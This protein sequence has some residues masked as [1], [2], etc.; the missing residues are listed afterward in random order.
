MRLASD[1]LHK[2]WVGVGDVMLDQSATVQCVDDG[3]S[4]AVF[5]LFS[6]RR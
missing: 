6:K 5:L 4:I 3:I 1:M 2:R